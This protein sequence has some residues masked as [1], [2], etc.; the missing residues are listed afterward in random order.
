[1]KTAIAIGALLLGQVR[2]NHPELLFVFT[3]V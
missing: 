1:L 3:G 2:A